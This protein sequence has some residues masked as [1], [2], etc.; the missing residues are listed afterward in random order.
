M[1]L[2][3]NTLLDLCYRPLLVTFLEVVGVAGHHPHHCKLGA[4]DMHMHI[5]RLNTHIHKL[6]TINMQ[7]IS[8]YRKIWI[9]RSCSHALVTL[10]S[11]SIGLTAG[12]GTSN[13]I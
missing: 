5:V 1:S 8:A 2:M 3:E 10:K 12:V 11:V 7:K 6:N 9:N 13:I 4:K